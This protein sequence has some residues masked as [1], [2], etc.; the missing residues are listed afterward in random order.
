MHTQ[1]NDKI[2]SQLSYK[3]RYPT[4]D[5]IV[6]IHRY[7]H[8]I[9]TCAQKL[10]WCRVKISNCAT[11]GVLSLLILEDSLTDTKSPIRKPTWKGEEYVKSGQR[12]TRESIQAESGRSL[13]F[14]RRYASSTKTRLVP[15]P[16]QRIDDQCNTRRLPSRPQSVTAQ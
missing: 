5:N 9:L 6:F 3:K 13:H 1:G 8:D 7:S 12:H 2:H 10:N 15:F 11:I 16:L 14:R 4:V